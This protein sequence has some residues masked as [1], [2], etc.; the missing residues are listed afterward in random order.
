[1]TASLSSVLR[2]A[3][4]T[5]D[6]EG[7][8]RQ[9]L[10]VGEGGVAGPEVVDGQLHTLLV[11]FVEH[12]ACAAGI[13][14]DRAFGDLKFEELG[15]DVVGVEEVGDVGREGPVEEAATADVDGDGDMVAVVEPASA[16]GQ[17]FVEIGRA[18]V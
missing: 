14:H 15:G 10:E 4:G 8:D 12:V 13:G 2:C 16:L 6:L 3:E 9:G 5:V 17:R 18:H 1:M 11:E 7:V